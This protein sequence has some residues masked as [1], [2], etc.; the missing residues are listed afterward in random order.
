MFLTKIIRPH[1]IYMLSSRSQKICDTWGTVRAYILFG[2]CLSKNEILSKNIWA[3]AFIDCLIFS[4]RSSLSWRLSRSIISSTI[5]VLSSS[6]NDNDPYFATFNV[7]CKVRKY[8]MKTS[9]VL[10]RFLLTNQFLF[11]FEF[12]LYQT[13]CLLS[14][15]HT[16]QHMLQV[17]AGVLFEFHSLVALQS[18]GNHWKRFHVMKVTWS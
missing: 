17:L 6:E 10:R 16:Q 1:R 4:L 15:Q 14:F 5:F 12:S 13:S 18:T 11:Y 3:Q 8:K 2:D 9:R 7:F